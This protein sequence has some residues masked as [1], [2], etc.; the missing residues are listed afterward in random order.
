MLHQ[1][2]AFAFRASEIMS[3]PHSFVPF[4]SKSAELSPVPIQQKLVPLLSLMLIN[5][6]PL[7]TA[8]PLPP[9]NF[10]I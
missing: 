1:W 3:Q 5:L 10:K 2:T 8:G 4:T 7:E 9:R 6:H